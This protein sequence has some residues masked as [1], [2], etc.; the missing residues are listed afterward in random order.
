MKSTRWP[1]IFVVIRPL[2]CFEVLDPEQNKTFNDH[3]LEVDY[4][5]S[6]VMFVV[7]ANTMNIP[8]ALADRMEVIRLSGYTEDEKRNIAVRYLIP[9]QIKLNGLEAKE[10]TFSDEVV[11]D[12][13]RY[14]ARSW[15]PWSRA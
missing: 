2:L 11:I 15:C 13:I 4:D 5:L 9:K 8:P 1:W 7:T 12:I 14:Y 3:Y 6:D 10:I